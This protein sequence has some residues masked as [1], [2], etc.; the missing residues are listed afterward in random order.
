M[1]ETANLLSSLNIKIDKSIYLFWLAYIKLIIAYF[2][3]K[4][5]LYNIFY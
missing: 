5:Y 3:L 1:I 4:F 2:S